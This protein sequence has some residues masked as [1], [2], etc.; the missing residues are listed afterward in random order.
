[1]L[2]N[3]SLLVIC[4]RYSSVYMLIPNPNLSLAPFHF[5]NHK[6]VFYVCR[7]ISRSTFVSFFLDPGYK[8]HHIFVFLCLEKNYLGVAAGRDLAIAVFLE[9]SPGEFKA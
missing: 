2:D 4:F 6:F 3:R 1:M 7:S 9:S 5:V 8:L